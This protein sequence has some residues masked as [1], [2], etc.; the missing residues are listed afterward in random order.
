MNLLW[1]NFLSPLENMNKA[2]EPSHISKY[3]SIKST[4]DKST[5]SL[6]FKTFRNTLRHPSSSTF[7]VQY[8][9]EIIYAKYLSRKVSANR[10]L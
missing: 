4:Q 8:F 1:Q 7:I 9:E 2:V 10:T 5:L 6:T 3:L